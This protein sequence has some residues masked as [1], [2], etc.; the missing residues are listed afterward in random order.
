[1]KLPSKIIATSIALFLFAAAAYAASNAWNGIDAGPATSGMRLWVDTSPTSGP[2]YLTPAELATFTQAQTLTP[3]G[4]TTP[5]T[6]AA[7]AGRQLSVLDFGAKCDGKTL[8]DVTTTSSSAVVSSASYTFTSADVGKYV[9]SASGATHVTKVGNTTAGSY[10]LSGL[11][12]VTTI[13][14]GDYVTGTNIPAGAIVVAKDTASSTAVTI[15]KAPAASG[16]SITFSFIAPQNTTIASVSGGNATLTSTA[17]SSVSGTDFFSFGTSDSTA[18]QAAVTAVAAFPN[19]ATLTIPKQTCVVNVGVQWASKVS[20]QGQGAGKSIIKFISDADMNGNGVFYAPASATYLN[21]LYDVQFRD[22]EI[23]LSAATDATHQTGNKGLQMQFTVRS[24]VD[25]LYVHDSPATCIAT[26]SANPGWVTN[27]TIQDCGRL[28]TSFPGGNGIG[29]GAISTNAAESYIITGNLA[30]NVQH[31]AIFLESEDGI[32][33][34]TAHAVISDN[35]IFS[36]LNA[37]ATAPES[38]AITDSGVTGIVITSNKIVGL[39]GSGNWNGIC[40]NR[41]TFS[42]PVPGVQEL[43]ANNRIENTIAGITLRYSVANPNPVQAAKVLIIG[44]SINNVTDSGIKGVT[45]ASGV[46][47]TLLINDNIISLSGRAGIFF[48]GTAAYNNVVVENN[49]LSN[50]G[51]VTGTDVERSG[52]EVASP[53]T[54]MTVQGNTAFDNLTGKQK[55][56]FSIA[57]G[58]TVTNAQIVDNNLRNNASSA[59]N[60]VGTLASSWVSGNIGY[61]PIGASAVTPGASPW[62]YTAGNTPEVLYLEGGTVS[63]VTK[64][65][66]SLATA[67]SATSSLAVPLDPGEAVIVTYTVAPTANKDQK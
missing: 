64:N 40:V 50:N 27:N 12:S 8:T 43:I 17:G 56:G 57:S 49:V 61:N 23:D 1:M 48:A 3:T 60:L 6:P 55:Y 62:T 59:L 10:V 28:I 31:N 35:V 15:S 52:I 32:T 4:G 58:I 24:V 51:A 2:S 41:G 21:P 38:C 5:S 44:N 18:I 29:E 25:H 65:G 53:I 33:S 47:D 19:G 39:T 42:T 63:N 45:G 34:T 22:F 9:T 67:L 16:S 30:I 54:N 14:L 46:M 37:D 7:I 13:S 66:I 26:D 11:P 20:I 36:S